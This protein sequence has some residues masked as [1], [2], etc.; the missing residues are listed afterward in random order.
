MIVLS[1]TLHT[2]RPHL[3]ERTDNRVD[4][5]SSL[6]IPERAHRLDVEL[7]SEYPRCVHFDSRFVR[8]FRYTRLGVGF[9]LQ[10]LAVALVGRVK[11]RAFVVKSVEVRRVLLN[12]RGRNPSGGAC[13]IG[14]AEEAGELGALGDGEMV[15]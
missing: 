1:S 12:R 2:N 9:D 8:V 3:S 10:I 5:S 6:N 15:K 7:D 13:V 14:P 4:T 11:N